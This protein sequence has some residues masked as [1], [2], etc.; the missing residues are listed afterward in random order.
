MNARGKNMKR[1]VHSDANMVGCTRTPT[2]TPERNLQIMVILVAIVILLPEA[3]AY[4]STT[5]KSL[6]ADVEHSAD[7]SDQAR[8]HPR[9]GVNVD[10]RIIEAGRRR[11]NDG[12]LTIENMWVS[13]R[14]LGA[15]NV[16]YIFTV[17]ASGL[18]I[19]DSNTSN[20]GDTQLL[21]VFPAEFGNS[22]LTSG[23]EWDILKGGTKRNYAF[24]TTLKP[25]DS[26]GGPPALKL[27]GWEGMETAGSTNAAHTFTLRISGINNPPARTGNEPEKTTGQ[28]RFHGVTG[29]GDVWD[30]EG[31]SFLGSPSNAGTFTMKQCDTPAFTGTASSGSDG[32]LM[33]FD[34]SGDI[35]VAAWVF[36]ADEGSGKTPIVELC[37]SSRQDHECISV[38][39]DL[40]N[41]RLEV[42]LGPNQNYVSEPMDYQ[43]A[44][45]VKCGTGAGNPVEGSLSAAIIACN[46]ESTCR[47]FFWWNDGDKDYYQL[48]V[49]DVVPM[50]GGGASGIESMMMWSKDSRRSH[51]SVGWRWVA[52]V[53]AAEAG[54]LRMHIDGFPVNCT[55]LTG[56]GAFAE[57][58][59]GIVRPSAWTFDANY[60]G[61]GR[62][63]PNN[64]AY[65]YFD[66][67]I[68]DVYVWGTQIDQSGSAN[69][70]AGLVLR[71]PR[72]GLEKNLLASYGSTY[73]VGAGQRYRWSSD[74]NTTG[75]TWSEDESEFRDLIQTQ[76]YED[77]DPEVKT[78]NK[79]LLDGNKYA[80]CVTTQE[81]AGDNFDYKAH[82]IE[83]ILPKPILIDSI[84]LFGVDGQDDTKRTASNDFTVYALEQDIKSASGSVFAFPSNASR[85]SSGSTHNAG[86]TVKGE[87]SLVHIPCNLMAKYIYIY[88]APRED[89]DD[90]A[91]LSFCEIEIHS[92]TLSLSHLHVQHAQILDSRSG[93]TVNHVTGGLLSQRS[94][95]V[96]LASPLRDPGAYEMVL[97]WPL[98][99]GN[100]N[101][102]RWTQTSNPA[103]VTQGLTV[104][105]FDGGSV[106]GFATSYPES[107]DG[108]A[109]SGLVRKDASARPSPLLQGAG[110]YFAV[111]VSNTSAAALWQ[112]GMR[113]PRKVPVYSTQL[114]A[115]RA[116][117]Q[118]D[119]DECSTSTVN[120]AVQYKIAFFTAGDASGEDMLTFTNIQ[121][122]TSNDPH[123]RIS[124]PAT[125]GDA[126][127]TIDD[128]GVITLE[129]VLT[130]DV[131]TGDKSWATLTTDAP[132]MLKVFPKQDVSIRTREVWTLTVRGL[133]NSRL[134]GPTSSLRVELVSPVRA[135]E[136][137]ATG[138]SLDSYCQPRSQDGSA[139]LTV[140][141]NDISGANPELE[142]GTHVDYTFQ[143]DI[144]P[145]EDVCQLIE[146]D[147]P[148][149]YSDI[150]GKEIFSL[151]SGGMLLTTYDMVAIKE[152]GEN[153]LR[154]EGLRL[155]PAETDLTFTLHGVANPR[156]AGAVG[157]FL[158]ELKSCAGSLLERATITYSGRFDPP[159]VSTGVSPCV[160]L[161][162]DVTAA[163]SSVIS[164]SLSPSSSSGKRYQR[165]AGAYAAGWGHHTHRVCV[166]P[167]V[168]TF[169][170][171]TGAV[172]GAVGWGHRNRAFVSCAGGASQAI[173]ATENALA[174][175]HVNVSSLCE[176]DT[177]A[178]AVAHV[179]SDESSHFSDGAKAVR[180]ILISTGHFRAEL[181][182]AAS[183]LENAEVT[184]SCLFSDR[185]P[186]RTVSPLAMDMSAVTDETACQHACQHAWINYGCRAY[187]W[188]ATSLKCRLYGHRNAPT[189]EATGTKYCRIF[190]EPDINPSTVDLIVFTSSAPGGLA[191]LLK[192]HPV[193]VIAMGDQSQYALGISSRS[194]KVK[195]STPDIVRR[196]ARAH[197]RM[198]PG[199]YAGSLHDP[200][201]ADGNTQVFNLEGEDDAWLGTAPLVADSSNAEVI[202]PRAGVYGNEVPSNAAAS[203]SQYQDPIF[204]LVA[205]RR[206]AAAVNAG[207]RV[208]F[209]LPEVFASKS[210]TDTARAFGQAC[211][212]AAAK[213]GVSIVQDNL[214]TFAVLYSRSGGEAL[215]GLELLDVI[216][217]HSPGDPSD[218]DPILGEGS[219][220]AFQA[221]HTASF[222][223]SGTRT[224]FFKCTS[225]GTE[226]GLSNRRGWV[227]IGT[228]GRCE[229]TVCR[230]AQFACRL[231]SP[232]DRSMVSKIRISNRGRSDLAAG[233]TPKQ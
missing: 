118:R 111:G 153:S 27:G 155:S 140:S 80:G 198:P 82:V 93:Q 101:F 39:W 112:C 40:T 219:V 145:H 199:L 208:A 105:H 157:N 144:T 204:P 90:K 148:E 77:G 162:V 74:R 54:K 64:P 229:Q 99:L 184:S 20:A 58:C 230:L 42:G 214:Q 205:Y 158:V 121:T 167:G 65:Q 13:D 171:Q 5:R 189:E 61:R 206:C 45:E 217:M 216:D 165:A 34:H 211:R 16:R 164:W 233:A 109:W 123:I 24:D 127:P 7:P 71:R 97:R 106:A 59:T 11:L 181:K 104:E 168:H 185:R 114:F 26:S 188:E 222:W 187:T 209:G 78:W 100:H 137:F 147:F 79:E 89:T 3:M 119:S 227:K 46:A 196:V 8:I 108:Q 126:W 69:L 192:N 72:V 95:P 174:Q 166:L 47:E 21:L 170:V 52:L 156:V 98:V 30:S 225:A 12:S 129:N 94:I 190:V 177:D 194:A 220:S 60:V 32:R 224:Y 15:Q 116:W 14:S 231:F 37:D 172:A 212:W 70:V 35:S 150:T 10:A 195:L 160:L 68:E 115:R 76:W 142:D 149:E 33:N 56:G 210:S 53:Y 200:S 4:T 18:A 143:L 120:P 221:S 213:K 152:G 57:E 48:K 43:Y 96:A 163:D 49:G 2:A 228:R 135:V 151:Q 85:C 182:T 41:N 201:F 92:P 29:E 122:M 215:H 50:C 62:T 51:A 154:V 203:L 113:G 183:L 134:S 102:N 31:A 128:I 36:V 125:F 141:S 193:P 81:N 130:G 178:R 131:Y 226:K 218:I 84:S 186:I 73:L 136:S 22:T 232:L 55:D 176:N 6:G 44:G 207:R 88:K 161:N 28:F 223:V 197:R 25:I 86:G 66:G 75:R 63:I 19:P 23:L 173:L 87:H 83:L 110:G 175:I 1:R 139:S 67:T 103:N 107:G 17:S 191:R 179:Y 133:R 138:L 202:I 117:V 38:S 124:F 9:A 132:Y 159:N 169:K 180:D 91:F 146:I